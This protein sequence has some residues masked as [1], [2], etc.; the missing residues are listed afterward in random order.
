MFTKPPVTHLW[1]S[2]FKFN[3]S[4]CRASLKNNSQLS[5][6][7]RDSR[8]QENRLIGYFVEMLKLATK[9]H[10]FFFNSYLF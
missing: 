1:R 4:S 5:V 2:L 10:L 3:V 9:P 6:D 7:S 8:K